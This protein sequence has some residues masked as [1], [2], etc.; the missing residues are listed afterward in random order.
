MNFCIKCGNKLAIKYLENEGA[1][2]FCNKCNEYRFEIFNVAVSLIITTED[3]KN[4]LLIQQYS[5]KRYILVAGYVNKGESAEEACHREVLEE[6]GLNI[7]K[8]I[9]QKTKYYEKS[10]TLMINYIGIVD[11]IFV[12]P[13]YEIDCYKWFSLEEAKNNIASPSLAEEFY[14]LFYERVKNNEI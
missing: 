5:R 9:F 13:N 4:V 12:K 1:I 14:L 2:P 8:L 7:N 6:V 3:Y 11:N 10:N